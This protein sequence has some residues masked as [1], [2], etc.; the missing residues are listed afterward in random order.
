MRKASNAAIG[1]SETWEADGLTFTEMCRQEY[2]GNNCVFAAGLITGHPIETAYLRW[3][4]DGDEGGM[5][6][7]RADE[8]AA[9][10]WV[11][12][13]AIWSGLYGRLEELDNEDSKT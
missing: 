10:A 5:L 7:L 8:L 13:G 6:M 4:K 2:G 11:A 1:T 3:S 12:Q 9:I